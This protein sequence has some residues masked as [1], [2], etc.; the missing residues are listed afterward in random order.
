ME[1]PVLL[2]MPNVLFV[3]EQQQLNVL[4]VQMDIIWMD[5]PV[6]FAILNVVNVL[7]QV[8]LLV[9]HVQLVTSLIQ[10]VI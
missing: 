5:L 9:K 3:L 6:L 8:L 2:V 10:V 1:L 4:H 7:E